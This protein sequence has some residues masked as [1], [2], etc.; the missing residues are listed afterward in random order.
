MFE[1]G[2]ITIDLRDNPVYNE[3]EEHFNLLLEFLD[4]KE[5]FE[6]HCKKFIHALRSLGGS[7]EMVADRLRDHWRDTVNREL[8]IEI[9]L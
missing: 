5:A 7:M 2:L 3:I 4:S 1:A 6:S 8:L 9:N